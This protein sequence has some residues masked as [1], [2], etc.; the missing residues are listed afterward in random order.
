M[1]IIMSLVALALIGSL[2]SASA[3]WAQGLYTQFNFW[4]ERPRRMHSIN[5]KKGTILP[6]GTEVS[7]VEIT[8]K[9]IRFKARGESFRIRFNPKFHPD[10]T[11]ETLGQKMFGIKNRKLLTA[12][13][14]AI[15]IKS[16]KEGVLYLGMSKKAVLVA[17]GF[18]PSHQTRS[19]DSKR[20]KFWIHR[21]RWKTIC[22]GD[23][24]KTI[25]CEDPKK[26]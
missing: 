19:L 7:D 21:F 2:F 12:G 17:Y 6:A 20:W 13:M 1:K 16:I 9:N 26:L 8:R 18:P 5:Y 25:K 4:Y 14:T 15:E 24:N 22:F 3:A 10:E 23:T 11:S